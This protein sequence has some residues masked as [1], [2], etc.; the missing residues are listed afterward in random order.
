[1]LEYATDASTEATSNNVCGVQAMVTCLVRVTLRRW[2][3]M[4]NDLDASRLVKD[5][6]DQNDLAAFTCTTT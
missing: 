5:H 6:I 4:A 1:M 3:A 2:R